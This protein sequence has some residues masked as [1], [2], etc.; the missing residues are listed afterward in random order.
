MDRKSFFE[1]SL[2]GEAV[3]V[4][5]GSFVV[6]QKEIV[7]DQVMGDQAAFK[8]VD[9]EYICRLT[10]PTTGV[11]KRKPLIIIPSRNNMDL[12]EYTL[13]NL[14]THNI[15]DICNVM[16]VDDRSTDDYSSLLRRP[17]LSLLRV[18]NSKGFNF[19]MLCNIG[20]YVANA[21]GVEEIILWNNDVWAEKREHLETIIKKHR[22]D[23]ATISGTKLLY[24]IRS[25]NGETE[26]GKHA[27]QRFPDIK[28][29]E[30]RGTVQFGG[31]S[32]VRTNGP[33][34]FSPAHKRRF[35]DAR[36]YL[37]NDDHAEIF[38]TGAFQVIDL[39]WLVNNGGMNP[40]LSKNFQDVDLCLRASVQNKK[41]M[42]YGKDVFLWHDDSL[43][44]RSGYD[45]KSDEQFA[46]DHVLFGMLWNDKIAKII[47]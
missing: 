40:S 47:L 33:I 20:A 34:L 2:F 18:D 36:H 42:Y 46:S 22:E 29:G 17:G 37:V 7:L 30:W 45:K 13:D 32:W 26:D 3:D 9:V 11:D 27:K 25:F 41:V 10:Q 21:S 39:R 8:L 24:P 35:G 16:V 12:I 38:V 6:H 28:D 44:F 5:A 43:T 14:F 15:H 31:S 23:Q 4:F 19:S 1:C